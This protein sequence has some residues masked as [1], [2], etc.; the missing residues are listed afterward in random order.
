MSG[1]PP[2]VFSQLPPAN[3]GARPRSGSAS[4]DAAS[5]APPSAAP[6]GPPLSAA[7]SFATLLRLLERGR[8]VAQERGQVLG[9][10]ALEAQVEVGDHRDGHRDHDGA[11]GDLDA[12]AVGRE[13][14]EDLAAADQHRVEDGGRAERV[15]DRHREPPGGEVLGGRDRDHAGEDRARAGRVDDAEAEAEHEARP[16][17]VTAAVAEGRGEARDPGLDAVGDRRQE[18]GDAEDEQDHDRER[19]Q[20]VAGQPERVDHVDEADDREREAQDDARDHPERAALT[21]GDAGAE[22]G[23]QDRKYARRE[24][25]SGTGDKGEEDEKSQAIIT[26]PTPA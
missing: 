6:W 26:L 19:A 13:P 23:G 2:G 20:E 1:S 5:A 3:S 7:S 4:P 14:V 12:R 16:E 10:R 9:D 25:R 11:E 21:A 8:R 18:Q 24:R 17:A 15:G 22:H